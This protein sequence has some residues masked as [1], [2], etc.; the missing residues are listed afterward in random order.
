M[1]WIKFWKKMR[2]KERAGFGRG[3]MRPHTAQPVTVTRLERGLAV[4]AES[5]CWRMWG[6][7][8]LPR[9]LSQ[10]SELQ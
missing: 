2:V 7:G 9:A 10:P 8:G 5:G 1:A 3:W 4:T 6:D